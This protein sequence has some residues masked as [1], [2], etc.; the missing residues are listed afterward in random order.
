MSM[1]EMA[2]S[3]LGWT[4]LPGNPTCPDYPGYEQRCFRTT[5]VDGSPPEQD[6]AAAQGCVANNTPCSTT[7]N[8]PGNVWCCP[9]GWPRPPGSPPLQPGESPPAPPAAPGV[10]RWFQQS[11]RQWWFWTGAVGLAAVAFFGYKEFQARRF[12]MPR[13]TSAFDEE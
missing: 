5:T 4:N 12:D 1:Y 8:N 9:P 6:F 13:L 10:A 2:T 7:S 11:V 3:G